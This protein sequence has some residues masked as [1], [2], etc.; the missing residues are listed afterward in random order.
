MRLHVDNEVRLCVN[1]DNQVR[2]NADDDEVW[3]RVDTDEVRLGVD[4]EVML[5][6]GDD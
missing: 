4:K 1:Y 2:L 5:F 3:L 6:A